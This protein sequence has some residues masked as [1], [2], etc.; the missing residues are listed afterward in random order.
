MSFVFHYKIR[1]Q[2][3]RTGLVWEA[4]TSRKGRMWGKDVGG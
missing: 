3:G 4:G 2:K 1:E